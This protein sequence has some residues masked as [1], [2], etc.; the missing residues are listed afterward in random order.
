MIILIISLVCI[1]KS[2]NYFMM[3]IFVI[4][5][6]VLLI[7][8]FHS[9]LWALDQHVFFKK[10][11][12]LTLWIKAQYRVLLQGKNWIHCSSICYFIV[13]DLLSME[14]LY[15]WIPNYPAEHVVKQYWESYSDTPAYL[16]T[17]LS[18]HAGASVSKGLLI[19]TCCRFFSFYIFCRV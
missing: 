12:I 2:F 8:F 14:L 18:G 6:F 16:R 11:V 10:P 1:I 15:T 9:E 13:D 3:I 19:Q 17:C 7:L 5:L 4:Y